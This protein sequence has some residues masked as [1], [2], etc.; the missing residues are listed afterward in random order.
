MLLAEIHLRRNEPEAAA[1]ELQDLLMLHRDLPNTS[2]MK[3]GVARSA[4]RC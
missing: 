1:G 4:G 3:E 2:K